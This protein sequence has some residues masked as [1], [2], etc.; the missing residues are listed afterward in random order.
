[1]SDWTA[2]SGEISRVLTKYYTTAGIIVGV[3]ALVVLYVFYRKLKSIDDR[4]YM[5]WKL[6]LDEK[7]PDE[8]DNT[9]ED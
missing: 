3:V 4:L 7:Y 1:M 9:E 8:D 2:V 5:I 6:K